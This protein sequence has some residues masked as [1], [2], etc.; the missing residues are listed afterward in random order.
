MELLVEGFQ[1]F[2]KTIELLIR[3]VAPRLRGNFG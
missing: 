2:P 1:D 3:E